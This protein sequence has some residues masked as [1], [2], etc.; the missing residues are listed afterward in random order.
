MTTE[1]PTTEE[2]YRICDRFEISSHRLGKGAFGVVVVG[3]DTETD[4]CV[5]IKFINHENL[6]ASSLAKTHLEIE[7]LQALDHPHVVRLLGHDTIANLQTPIGSIPEGTVLVLDYAAQ[8]EL[9]TMIKETGFM[10]EKLARTYFAQLVS[11]LLYCHSKGV[12]HRDLKPENILLGADFSLK[13]ADF[14]L[15]RKIDPATT[16]PIFSTD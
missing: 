16:N 10:D 5:A 9:F 15:S 8:G 3:A 7:A 13:I 6:S 2:T 4:D 14:G 12:Y 1:E 11:G